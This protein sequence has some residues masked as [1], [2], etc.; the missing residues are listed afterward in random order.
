MDCIRREKGFYSRDKVR[1]YLRYCLQFEEYEGIWV[2]KVN[3]ELM[4][5]ILAIA[6]IIL[7][8]L[9]RQPEAW[10]KLNMDSV[11]Y[12]EIFTGEK[13]RFE[14][15]RAAKKVN[16]SLSTSK[17]GE[18]PKAAK[19]PKTPKTPSNDKESNGKST[20]VKGTPSK[21]G[22]PDTTRNAKSA[23]KSPKLDAESLAKEFIK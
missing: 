15:K 19:T 14:E 23:T 2:V 18:T 10:K 5:S 16:K 6:F 7:I 9:I 20:P 13:P 4:I 11:K 21:K 17:G 12:T 3:F 8:L 1:L 22:Q